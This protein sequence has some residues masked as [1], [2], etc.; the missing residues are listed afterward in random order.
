MTVFPLLSSGT[1]LMV[2]RRKS[3]HLALLDTFRT[4]DLI[5]PTANPE[6]PQRSLGLL[7]HD[8]PADQDREHHK[9]KHQ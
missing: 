9:S 8:D 3:N 7:V 4:H 1:L 5:T 6:Y 2:E